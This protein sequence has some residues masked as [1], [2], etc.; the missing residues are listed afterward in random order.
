MGSTRFFLSDLP[1]RTTEQDLRALFQDYGYVERVE[2]KT[3]EQ[4]VDSGQT[5]E[6]VIAFVTVQTEDAHYCLN[7]LN[8]QK[9][10]G[11]K[12]KVSLAKESFLDRLKRE[13]DEGKEQEQDHS[14]L[15]EF[16]QSSSRLLAHNTQNK[17]RVFGE[18]EE[19]NDDEVATELLITK[20]RAAN[21]IHNGKIV[22]QQE[23]DVKPL[24]II[25]QQKKKKPTKENLLDAKA[26][27]A[28]QKRKESLNKMKQQHEQK[29]SAIQMALSSMEAG[30]A[31]RIKFSDAEEEE[32]EEKKEQKKPKPQLFEDAYEDEA[33]EDQEEFLLPQHSGKK[34]EK[35]VEMQS[36][37]SLD[38][39]F[40]ITANF[41]GEEDEDE[42]EEEEDEEEQ[43]DEEI[44]ER[45]YQMGILE[46][47]IGR[48]ID[49]SK[50]AEAAKSAKNKKM[51]RFDPGKEEHQKLLR[52]K[53]KETDKKP[54]KLTTAENAVENSAPVSQSA[55]YVVTDTLK[56]SLK[57]RGE[58]FS[59]LDMFGPSHE[60]AAAERQDQLEKLGN[61]K[62]LVNKSNKLGMGLGMSSVNPFSYDSSDSEDDNA[63]DNDNE[64]QQTGNPQND[65]VA[66]ENE[67]PSKK[68]PGKQKKQSQI[69][70]ETFFIPKNDVRLKEGA[71]FFKACKPELENEN[72]DQVKKRLKFL[73][74]KKI[75]KTQKN[76]PGKAIK[77]N[78]NNKKAK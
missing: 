50:A 72:Y 66:K 18:H 76:M 73:I 53:T 68:K 27:I 14:Q 3:K 59:L 9:L 77:K 43:K 67:E 51:L 65:K 56:E 32:E 55:F 4:F 34:G 10:H 39:R 61:E 35:L 26:S 48:K 78:K 2:L 1:H 6:K 24:H 11:A 42:Q 74:T 45:N 49:T 15:N 60:E 58:G 44:N 30:K 69:F 62:I 20:K 17:R 57:T 47:V 54:P 70:M 33:G 23:H 21:S 7:E 19:I 31:K 46:Q 8:W 12:L 29:K 41:V 16:N 64:T 37:Q 22:I 36:K 5:A 28:D 25:E 40:R 71:K 13:R 52:I 63:D 75:A 38:P